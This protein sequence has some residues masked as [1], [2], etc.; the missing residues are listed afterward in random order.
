MGQWGIEEST[1]PGGSGTRAFEAIDYK[2]ELRPEA[3]DDK[4][5]MDLDGVSY[6]DGE[7]ALQK[8]RDEGVLEWEGG[9]SA[10]PRAQTPLLLTRWR[11]PTQG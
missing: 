10:P 1:G 11:V 7:A 6:E 5:R 9:K 4:G 2:L 8:L 3:P